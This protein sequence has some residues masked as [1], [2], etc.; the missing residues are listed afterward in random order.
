M[1]S[2]LTAHRWTR[3][4]ASAAPVAEHY[5]QPLSDIAREADAAHYVVRALV[6]G[7]ISDK[8]ELAGRVAPLGGMVTDEIA[9]HAWIF[10]EEVRRIGGSWDDRIWA[11]APGYLSVW[12]FDYGWKIREPEANERL[13]IQACSLAAPIDETL[14]IKLTIYQP[15]PYHPDG[16][17]R[18]WTIYRPQLEQ[19]RKW[20]DE[21]VAA[22][23]DANAPA[24]PGSHCTG[25]NHAARCRAL[26]ETCYAERERPQLARGGE[27]AEAAALSEELIHAEDILAMVQARLSSLKAETEARLRTGEYVPGWFL[28]SGEGRRELSVPLA[29]ASL[30]LGV[31]ATKQ[32]TKTPA[33]L[34]RDGADKAVLRSITKRPAAAAQLTRLTDKMIAK[35]MKNG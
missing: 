19:W 5:Q 27:R 24:R 11:A 23:R 22:T 15:R 25:C 31:E 10:A 18:T 14:T 17:W 30:L 12:L 6:R 8:S 1:L 16:K 7:E 29:V 32:V 2:D 4:P 34:E 9:E 20:L 21:R 13:L 35:R 33:E 3:C 28:Q 26:R